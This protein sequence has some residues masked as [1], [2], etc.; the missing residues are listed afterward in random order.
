MGHTLKCVE[1]MHARTKNSRLSKET[2]VFAA[3]TMTLV[4]VAATG[5]DAG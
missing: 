5:I 3:T 2:D 4:V 1:V